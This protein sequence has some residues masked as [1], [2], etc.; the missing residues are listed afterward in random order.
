MAEKDPSFRCL[1]SAVEE[2]VREGAASFF[3]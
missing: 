1:R 2:I 3:Y